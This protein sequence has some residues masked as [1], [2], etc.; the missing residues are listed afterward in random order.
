MQLAKSQITLICR[1]HM[2]CSATQQQSHDMTHLRP[3]LDS[4]EGISRFTP[5]NR[6]NPVLLSNAH[7][8]VSLLSAM[9][10]MQ[11]AINPF[12]LP[13]SATSE[14]FLTRCLCCSPQTGATRIPSN[15][16]LSRFRQPPYAS[17]TSTSSRSYC[18]HYSSASP[19]AID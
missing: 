1:K 5:C 12:H 8:I 3:C 13:Q 10:C 16:Q 15:S 7:C 2:S 17:L 11:P 4:S 19:G 9:P 6:L 18:E 14:C